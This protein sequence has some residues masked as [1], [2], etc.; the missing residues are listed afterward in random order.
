MTSR[1]LTGGP[2]AHLQVP[3][4]QYVTDTSH[5]LSPTQGSGSSTRARYG[6]SNG[7]AEKTTNGEKKHHVRFDGS[8]KADAPAPSSP[9]INVSPVDSNVNYNVPSTTTNQQ[10]L[11]PLGQGGDTLR[12]QLKP[13]DCGSQLGFAWPLWR[14]WS[15]L[16]VIFLVQVSMN[17]NTTLYSNAIRGNAG[18]YDVDVSTVVWG[19][20]AG[21]LLA[22]AFGC[23]LWAP[24]SEEYGR[25]PV[26]Q[27]SLFLVNMFGLMTGF[28]PNFAT[29]AACR[30]LGGLATAG[31]SVTLAVITDIFRSDDDWYQYATLFIVLSSV[32]GSII[33]PIVGGF[34]EAHVEDWRWCIWVQVIFGFA[35]SVL[36]WLTVPETRSTVL[37]DR[38][39]KKKRKNPQA[40][41]DAH[42]Y[43]PSEGQR[44]NWHE[45]LQVW[46]RPFRMFVTEPIVLALSLLSGFSDAL[47]FMMIQSFALVYAQWDFGP[48]QLGLSFLPIGLGYLIGY[49]SFIPAIRRNIA[50]RRRAPHNEHAQYETRLWWLLWTVPLLPLGLLVFAFTAAWAHPP[51]HWVGSMFASCMIGIAN[52][53][54]Y[55]ATIDYVLRAY[56]P[57]AASATGGNGWARDFLAGLLTPAAVPM[58]QKLGIF[59][60]TMMLFAISVAF[61]VAVYVVYW[62]GATLR[63]RSPFAQTLKAAEDEDEDH[64]VMFLPST[65]LPGSRVNSRPAT[66]HATPAGSRRES[67]ELAPIENARP[68]ETAEGAGKERKG[69]SSVTEVEG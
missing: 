4:T 61:C 24:W 65:S 41:L 57:Y 21:F 64:V 15:I 17:F 59:K 22:Y 46:L 11:P 1:S 62:Y 32:G 10:Q 63:T 34:V 58:Y 35:V 51:V 8:S 45:V 60:A 49:G 66:R 36:H 2:S 16:A 27:A 14:K 56:G 6:D 19:G 28:A 31:G 33:G 3:T 23:E 43:G 55:M 20:A 7:D 52:F 54:I 30:V 5:F 25:K 13:S 50:Q 26:L 40:P 68:A 18:T 48:V 29:H 67:L 12:Y 42:T 69:S 39:A 38:I 47:I 44:V 53:A 37:M 9:R